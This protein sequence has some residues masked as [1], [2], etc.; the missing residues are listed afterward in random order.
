M[1]TMET[2]MVRNNGEM[3]IKGGRP[4]EAELNLGGRYTKQTGRRIE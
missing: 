4:K 2:H 1:R 3:V